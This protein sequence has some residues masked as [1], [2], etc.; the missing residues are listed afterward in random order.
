MEHSVY[1]YEIVIFV[2]SRSVLSFLCKYVIF[3]VKAFNENDFQKLSSVVW[4]HTYCNSIV[5][6]NK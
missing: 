6:L 2:M 3:F 1:G 4:A 5:C